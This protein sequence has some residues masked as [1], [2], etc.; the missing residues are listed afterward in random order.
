MGIQSFTP[1]GGGGTPGFDYIAS[2]RMETYNRSWAQAGA[3]G[4]Y[5]VDSNT[6]GSGYV[7]FVSSGATTGG[8]LNKVINVPHAFTSINIVAPAGDYISLSKVAVKQTTAFANPFAAFTTVPAIINA[9][10]NFILPNVAM[11]IADVLIVGGGGS[12]GAGHGGTHGGGGGGGGGNVIFLSGVPVAGA[13]GVTVGSGGAASGT[14]SSGYAGGT[15][16]FGNVYALGGGGGG[17]WNTR[18]AVSGVGGNGGGGGAGGGGGGATGVTQTSSTGLGTLYSPVF[19]G[20]YS[21]GS[22]ANDTGSNRRG[23]GGGGAAGNGSNGGNGGG[24][25]AGAGYSSSITGTAQNYGQ[26]GAGADPDN[27]LGSFS[28]NGFF[29]AGG[30]GTTNGHANS[31]GQIGSPGN[32]G[33]VIVRY[34]LA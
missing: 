1:S 29:G 13:T 20:G 24:G 5:I 19:S 30:Q 27:G 26:G 25:N 11:P 28:T 2:I 33:V 14:N 23:G 21:G 32:N 17:S 7:Y 18:T 6:K 22:G 15:S 4:N 31:A 16:Y 34:Y 3:A 9:S 10:G 8:Y 12:A